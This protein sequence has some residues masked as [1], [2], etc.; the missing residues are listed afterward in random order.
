M[1]GVTHL[2]VRGF[3][4]INALER[5]ELGSLNV[6]IGPNGAGK[7]NLLDLFRMLGAMANGRLRLFAAKEDGPDALLHRGRKHTSEAEIELPFPQRRLPSR[8]DGG[9]TRLGGHP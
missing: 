9:W 2:T 6:L 5:F 8:P 7:S 4:S 1:S 3:K